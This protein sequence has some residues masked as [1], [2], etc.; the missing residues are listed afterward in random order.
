MVSSSSSICFSYS[1]KVAGE[2]KQNVAKQKVASTFRAIIAMMFLERLSN[3]NWMYLKEFLSYSYVD[4]NCRIYIKCCC[5]EHTMGWTLF[6]E[7]LQIQF[8]KKFFKS[9]SIE[10][11]LGAILKLCHLKIGNFWPPL[12]KI[13]IWLSKCKNF[14]LI[15]PLSVVHWRFSWPNYETLHT[16]SQYFTYLSYL[17][18][19]A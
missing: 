8:Q 12:C 13:G 17:L 11:K 14:I 2:A 5:S 18:T 3:A 15:W 9:L 1:V 7:C 4:K 6:L 19:L 16:L 10:W